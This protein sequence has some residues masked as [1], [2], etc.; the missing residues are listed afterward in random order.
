MLAKL[1]CGSLLILLTNDLSEGRLTDL[2]IELGRCH[3]FV[4]FER[5]AKLSLVP[6]YFAEGI[7]RQELLI[8]HRF[9]IVKEKHFLDVK[10]ELKVEQL[11]LI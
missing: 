2:L 5:F 8:C 6:L 3:L 7:D 9:N 1:L 10:F 11:L 4:L